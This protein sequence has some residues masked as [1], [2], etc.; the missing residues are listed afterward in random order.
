MKLDWFSLSF[1]PLPI[2]CARHKRPRQY[3]L[4]LTPPFSLSTTLLFVFWCC[5][6]SFH[7]VTKRKYLRKGGIYK[8]WGRCFHDASESHL[9]IFSARRT[10]ICLSLSPVHTTS[11][12]QWQSDTIPLISMESW[13]FPATRAT[14]SDSDLG[15][16]MGRD[17]RRDQVQNPSTFW[18]W[19]VTFGSESQLERRR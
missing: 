7:Q 2:G 9:N 18:K 5:L 11:D 19:R 12:T 17:Q 8:C 6:I 3:L 10:M 15:V 13:R 16:R 4:C 14:V 1:A